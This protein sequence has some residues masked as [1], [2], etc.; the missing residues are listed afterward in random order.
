MI[1]DNALSRSADYVFVFPR[2]QDVPPFDGLCFLLFAVGHN[3]NLEYGAPSGW[4]E[5]EDPLVLQTP[6]GS[7]CPACLDHIKI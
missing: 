4:Y 2:Q 7:S 6:V 3:G 5:A 1:N